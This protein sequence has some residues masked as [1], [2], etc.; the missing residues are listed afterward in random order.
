MVPFQV[1]AILS[2]LEHPPLVEL[3]PR[4]GPVPGLRGF[5]R[6]G[7]P[8][9]AGDRSRAPCRSRF[10]WFCQT[11]HTCTLWSRI[12]GMVPF[13]VCAVLTDLAH[14]PLLETVPGPLAVPGLCGFVRPGTPILAGAR[15]KASC[16]SRSARFLQTWH[17]WNW[18]IRIIAYG[19]YSYM[20]LYL[21]GVSLFTQ[22]GSKH[23]HSY[24]MAGKT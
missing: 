9:L 23:E 1:C 5:D 4:H 21:P 15:S 2:D 8:T 22:Y 10:V 11:W 3:P 19:I 14:P 20:I 6:P 16:R 7:T 17:T 24:F 12:Y 18:V 13:Q